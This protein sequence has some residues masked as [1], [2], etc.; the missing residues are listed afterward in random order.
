METEKEVTRVVESLWMASPGVQLNVGSHTL[1]VVYVRSFGRR[2][3]VCYSLR[4]RFSHTD[5][6]CLSLQ[7]FECYR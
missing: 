5:T 3:R 1:S 4:L 6:R 7:K 2:M